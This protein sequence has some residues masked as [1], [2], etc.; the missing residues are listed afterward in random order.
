MRVGF[1]GIQCDTPNLGVM[2]L[3]YSAVRIVQS[4][5]STSTE[6]VIFSRNSQLALKRMSEALGLAVDQVT[7]SPIH[8]NSPRAV[9]G[10][11]KALRACD[12]VLDFT[13]GDSFADIYGLRRLL[14]NLFD[15]QLVLFSGS[16]LVI[17]PQTVGP[18]TNRLALWW[19]THIINRATDVFTRDEPSRTFLAGIT[20]R[21]VNLTT[22]VA[23]KLPWNDSAPDPRRHS[24]PP[25]GLNVS[26]LLWSGGYTKDNQFG[27]RA[28]YRELCRKL[29]A[30]LLGAGFEVHLLPHVIT[31]EGDDWEDDV[32]ASQQLHAEY[33]QCFLAPRFQDPVE[34]KSYIA[35][36][37]A[38]VGARM[39]ATIA[40]LT[41]GVPPVP[42]AYSRK[43][44][45]FFG[46]LGYSAI[47]DLTELNTDDAVE[48]AM[49][50]VEDRQNLAKDTELANQIAETRI[51]V[52]T[53]RLGVLAKSATRTAGPGRPRRGL[54]K[55]G[56]LDFTP[57]VRQGES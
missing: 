39:H 29:A 15:K 22:D 56:R 2:A 37:E 43:F 6:F 27:L 16:P 50:Y 12:L 42:L 54:S 33:P 8:H 21:H 46:N 38:L 18:L 31:P 51:R 25:I 5:A 40:A 23:V 7:A 13:G 34:A 20:S 36:M 26:G 44:A 45:G 48:R 24:G 49:K 4:I 1:L 9:L 3:C 53:E 55:L 41:T 28:D 17:G 32:T 30:A 14:L 47:I 19:A 10:S 35:R 57:G 11:L 52:F